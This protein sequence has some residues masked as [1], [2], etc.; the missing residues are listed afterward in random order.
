MPDNSSAPGRLERVLATMIAAI[1]LVSILCMFAV[2]IGQLAGA[3]LGEGIWLPIAVLPSIGLP[4]AFLLIIVL[5][6]VS[7]R[8]RGKSAKDARR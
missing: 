6:V 2:L 5:L 4:I 8:R 3:P 7:I 1:V